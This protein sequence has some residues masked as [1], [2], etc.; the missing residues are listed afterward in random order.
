VFA[1][2]IPPHEPGPGIA[3]DSIC[4]NRPSVFVYGGTIMP[5]NYKGQ[6]VD[7]VSVFEA[8]GAHANK[9]ISDRQ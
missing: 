8:V 7:V 5:G 9:D 1:V 6:A 2:Y 3:L 4:F